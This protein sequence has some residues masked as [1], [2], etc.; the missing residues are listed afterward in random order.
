MIRVS[1]FLVV[2]AFGL[3]AAG[4][5]TS[6]LVLV[7]IAIGVGVVSLL[8]L[9]AGIMR[10]R[11]EV[12]GPARPRAADHPA[13]PDVTSTRETAVPVGSAAATGSPAETGYGPGRDWTTTAQAAQPPSR[14][15]DRDREEF[16]YREETGFEQRSRGYRP[17]RSGGHGPEFDDQHQGQTAGYGAYAW[18]RESESGRRDQP[19]RPG[20]PPRP[21]VPPRSG[22]PRRDA[23]AAQDWPVE[24]WREEERR[25]GGTTRDRDRPA[26]PWERDQASDPTGRDRSVPPWERDQAGDPVGRDRAGAPWEREQAGD[27]VGRDRTG[28]PWDRERAG[29]PGDREQRS[30]E[31]WNAGLGR[32]EPPSDLGRRPA[33]RR[34]EQR[35]AKQSGAEQSRAEQRADDQR[36]TESQPFASAQ[37][38]AGP[39]DLRYRPA[40]FWRPPAG[41]ESTPAGA[42]PQ[43]P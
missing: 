35:P 20:G 33:E 18:Q 16:V 32:T 11:D 25:P 3:L 27:P 6:R 21:G 41:P 39:E 9:V 7:Y 14:A 31:P 26:A 13:E 1:P 22:T 36:R 5:V 43:E 23:W 29:E 12:F 38:P 15:D 34:G 10:N 19:A 30:R 37:P 4:A 42:G 17:E 8:T 40:D 28:A 2:A 24:D